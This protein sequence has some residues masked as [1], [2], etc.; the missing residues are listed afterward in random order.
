MS[1]KRL[2]NIA[3]F[4]N[5]SILLPLRGNAGIFRK[6]LS[7][8]EIYFRQ[9]GIELIVIA[10][11]GTD[12]VSDLAAAFP[13]I[14]WKIIFVASQKGQ[15]LSAQ[16]NTGLQH[17]GHKYVLF[18]DPHTALLSDII[19]RS[20]Y[21]LQHYPESFT[22]MRSVD[23]DPDTTWRG[24]EPPD[25]GILMVEKEKLLKAGGFGREKEYRRISRDLQ[26]RLERAEVKKM[27]IAEGG[28]LLPE[29]REGGTARNGELPGMMEAGGM[30][31]AY[32]WTRE[33][34]PDVAGLVLKKFGRSFLRAQEDLEREY[35][36]ICLLQTRNE[37]SNLPEVLQ[38]LDG[39][40]DGII[41]LDDGSTDGSY[42]K[43]NA[44]KLLLKVQK[45]YTGMFNDLENRNLLL[46]L[47]YL[48]RSE[49][50]LFLDADE[51]FASSRPDLDAVLQMEEVD[52]VSFRL[53]HI[54]D[55]KD[56]YRKDLP[57][58]RG[59]VLQRYRLFRSKGFLQIRANRELHFCI[60]PF[61]QNKY[62][63]SLL[64]LHYGLMDATVR[65][66]KKA[67]YLSQD[68][69]GK[70]QGYRYDYLTD[71]N[72]ELASLDHLIAGG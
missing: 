43:A 58:G 29:E 46:E 64:L 34:S 62:H 19:Y 60:T 53:V 36:V 1:R 47:A 32:D 57:E 14:N 42:E 6:H 44:D 38:H 5:V 15:A 67:L 33:R 65:Q 31:V 71:E 12:G 39:I 41:L 28:F 45:T 35:R 52:T 3:D 72:P 27:V 16:L 10:D 23:A 51:R 4:F 56:Q 22:V 54:W 40:C 55:K 21:I 61:R 63:S 50:F 68:A 70:K 69:G 13:F 20:R 37:G 7:A 59:G 25:V 8:S 9:N 17:A 30:T 2:R 11:E 48:F 18:M 49:W 24:G 66:N 26:Q